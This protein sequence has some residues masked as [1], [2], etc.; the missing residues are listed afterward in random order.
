MLNIIVDSG[1]AV[2]HFLSSVYVEA[3]EDLR[4][5]LW[6]AGPL[7]HVKEEAV[8]IFAAWAMCFIKSAMLVEHAV[9]HRRQ[10]F[11]QRRDSVFD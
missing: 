6:H 3:V 9:L 5:F 4:G 10:C 7:V 1:S 11:P 2:F 8:A